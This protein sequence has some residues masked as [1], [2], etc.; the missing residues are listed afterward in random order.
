MSFDRAAPLFKRLNQGDAFEYAYDDASRITGIT[1]LPGNPSP[2][3]YIEPLGSYEKIRREREQQVRQ[4][5]AMIPAIRCMEILRG[6][7]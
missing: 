7:R 4:I 3:S 1:S 5:R 6:L 2:A